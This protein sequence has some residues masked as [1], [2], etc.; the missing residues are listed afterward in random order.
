MSLSSVKSKKL[1][2]YIVIIGTEILNGR[3]E[4]AHFE[5]VRNSLEKY[6]HEIHSLS[7]I[8]DNPLLIRQSFL[9]ARNDKDAILI[10]FGGIGSTPDDITRKISAEVFRDS[11]MQYH[12]KFVDDIKKRFEDVNDH[13]LQMA[14]L[15]TESK[16]LKNPINNMSGFYLDDKYFF[17]PGF[18]QMAH[19]MVEQALI[20]FIPQENKKYR[21]TLSAKCSENTLIDLMLE[22]PSTIEISSLPAINVKT[23]E[24]TISLIS[25][26]KEL[27]TKW[28]NKFKNYLNENKIIFV[29]A[30][31][32]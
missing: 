8:K 23:A 29:E 31:N 28:F 21:R 25:Y 10:S 18:P 27:T 12:T 5:F 32:I 30:E 19:P 22:V 3:R 20:E 24:V 14:Y 6:N 2:F 4:D 13:R 1:R 11:K 26:D 17:V 7:I 15:P 9:Q 16:L